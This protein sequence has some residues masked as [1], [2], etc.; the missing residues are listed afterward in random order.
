V[1]ERNLL[2]TM[3]EA[4]PD[5]MLIID[6]AGSIIAANSQTQALLGFTAEEMIGQ[7]VE[8]LMP[9]R[10]RDAH[11]IHLNA[12]ASAPAH[13]FMGGG[14]MA[15]YASRK[16][17]SEIEIEVSLR[18]MALASESLFVAAIRDITSRRDIEAQ[19][20]SLSRAVEQSGSIVVMTDCDGHIEYVNPRFTDV[21]GY[22]FDEVRGSRMP[23][24]RQGQIVPSLAAEAWQIIR[25]GVEWRGQFHNYRKN[26]EMYWVSATISP[27]VDSAGT[28]THIVAIE[29]DITERKHI[30]EVERQQRALAH[31]LSDTAATLNASVEVSEVMER[32]LLHLE[33]LIP[34]D[35]ADI[36]LIDADNARL[37]RTR[38]YEKFTGM[39]S[40]EG[41]EMLLTQPSNLQEMYQTGMP[42]VIPDVLQY[43]TW[44]VTADTGWGRSHVGAPIKIDGEVI[45][46]LALLSRTPGFYSATHAEWLQTFADQVAIA[47]RNAR[48]FEELRARSADLEASNRELDAYSYSVAHD[49]KSPLTIV[50]GYLEMLCDFEQ[51]NLSP[52]G[53]A[54]LRNASTSA[55]HMKQII[56]SLLL[57]AQLRSGT[58]SLAPVAMRP[59]VDAAIHRA[60]PEIESRHVTVQISGSLPLVMGYGPWLEEVV[61]NLISNAVKYIG[62]HNPAPCIIIT[63]EERD[64]WVQYT[65][66]DNGMGIAP[67]HHARLFDMFARFH[68]EQSE[69][70]GLGLSIVQR[71]IRKLN[72]KLGVESVPGQGSRFW[73]AL[74][75]AVEQT[76][77]SK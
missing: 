51:Q 77:G 57:L 70:L 34:Y 39:N 27:V 23:I 4:A 19:L 73:F 72:G 68:T 41:L 48:L 29:E 14:G 54:M 67:E 8:I 43:P 76:A 56:E 13:R 37:E 31:A 21:T 63:A 30:E 18:P 32:I 33:A 16:D 53:Q 60:R 17:G 74:P 46:F 55:Y 62:P 15:L 71:I 65:I 24:F 50:V 58:Q 38:G 45:G 64:G 9:Q 44:I 10:Y 49:L 26:G 61:A 6:E 35:A 5:A 1:K 25:G 22:T 40:I 7:P 69:G 47:L 11:S 12:Y 3:L 66:E 52:D 28:V 2:R 59:I 20:N 36:F 75:A 42:I